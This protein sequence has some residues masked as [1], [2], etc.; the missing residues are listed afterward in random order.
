[1][2]RA[3]AN[4]GVQMP[5]PSASAPLAAVPAT[6]DGPEPEGRTCADA[7]L[8]VLDKAGAELDRGVIIERVRALSQEWG[9]PKP[10]SI[11]AIGLALQSLSS[12]GRIAKPQHNSYAPLRNSI[13]LMA[14]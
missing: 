4:G 10:F 7:V 9:R 6:D 13:H 11:R 8:A 14:R 2:D 1:M 3:I 5:L 12:D